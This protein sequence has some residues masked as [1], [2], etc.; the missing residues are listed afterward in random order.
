MPTDLPALA[1]SDNLLAAHSRFFQRLHR[2]YAGQLPL[3]PPGL[4]VASS[5]EV[6]LAALRASGHDLPTAL[7]ILR[8]IVIERTMRLDCAGQA[9]L[10]EVTR[11]MTDLAELALD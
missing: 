7:R 5:M 4:P 2:R 10:A 1:R 11:A 8:Q 9:D 3:L 6:A